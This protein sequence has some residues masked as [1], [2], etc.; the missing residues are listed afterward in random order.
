MLPRILI[1]TFSVVLMVGASW[2]AT[3]QGFD[4]VAAVTS[5]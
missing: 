1:M 4:I 2:L 3:R 5:R